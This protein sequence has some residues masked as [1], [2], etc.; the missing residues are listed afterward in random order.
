M[1][2]LNPVVNLILALLCVG[3]YQC[4][5]PAW[6]VG[7]AMYMIMAHIDLAKQVRQ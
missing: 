1:K 5:G 2:Y 4:F 3:V 6:A 7:Y